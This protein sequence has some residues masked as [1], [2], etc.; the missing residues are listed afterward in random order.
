M[1]IYKKVLVPLDGSEFSECTLGHVNEI[2]K[3]FKVQDV[4]LLWVMEPLHQVAAMGEDWRRDAEAK[5][6]IEA[7]NY[8]TK[9]ADDLKKDGLAV[10][11]V[12][13]SGQPAEVILDYVKQNQVDLIIM[14]THGRSGVSRWFLGSV[15]D[16]V[17]SHSAAPVLVVSPSGCRV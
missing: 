2:A 4:V 13:S 16:R 6:Q 7:K 10:E 5:A 8:L 17:V 15:T 11:T 12:V 3:G 9:I 1:N 14:S